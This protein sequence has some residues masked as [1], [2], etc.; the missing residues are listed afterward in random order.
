MGIMTSDEVNGAAMESNVLDEPVILA[1]DTDALT[2]MENHE[3]STAAD[4]GVPES[5][6]PEES[7]SVTATAAE[8]VVDAES[9]SMVVDAESTTM[10][11]DEPCPIAEKVCRINVKLPIVVF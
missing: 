4:E 2:T 11:T 7:S 5:E 6:S 8:L 9:T 10:E 1:N 3:S